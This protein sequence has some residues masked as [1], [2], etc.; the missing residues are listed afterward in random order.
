MIN[1]LAQARTKA[2]SMLSASYLLPA[3]LVANTAALFALDRCA[4][5]PNW[6]KTAAALFL[7]F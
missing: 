3:I 6:V 2:E 7:G 4:G 5:I 1:S